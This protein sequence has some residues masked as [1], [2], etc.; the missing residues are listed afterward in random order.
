MNFNTV[1]SIQS[2]VCESFGITLRDMLGKSRKE[3]IP[4]VKHVAIWL[5][6]KRL[7]QDYIRCQDCGRPRPLQQALATAESEAA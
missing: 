5:C 6:W 1:I 7:P 4:T 2:L 3:P